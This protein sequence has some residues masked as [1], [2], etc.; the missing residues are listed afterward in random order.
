MLTRKVSGMKKYFHQKNPP[1][2][3][4]FYKPNYLNF[5]YISNKY[6]REMAIPPIK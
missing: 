2:R 3:E 5:L 4:D 1:K 6:L